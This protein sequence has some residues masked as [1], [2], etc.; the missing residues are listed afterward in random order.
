MPTVGHLCCDATRRGHFC[1][2]L[3]KRAKSSQNPTYPNFTDIT[4]T[5][6]LY[7]I[8]HT[9][10]YK[11]QMHTKWRNVLTYA[12]KVEQ[13]W[14]I[15]STPRF[16]HFATKNGLKTAESSIQTNMVSHSVALCIKCVFCTSYWGLC[17]PL[18][19]SKKDPWRE[20]LGQAQTPSLGE[21]IPFFHLLDRT[22]LNKLFTLHLYLCIHRCLLSPHAKILGNVMNKNPQN[23]SWTIPWSVP[24]FMHQI[25]PT[26]RLPPSITY[27]TTS[28]RSSSW[29]NTLLTGLNPTPCPQIPTPPTIAPSLL[30]PNPYIYVALLRLLSPSLHVPP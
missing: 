25:S 12:S 22:I 26:M 4:R 24:S 7:H 16:P 5:Y 14:K 28:W 20:K 11:N 9:K 29:P 1:P 21:W 17:E 8:I 6:E 27:T 15:D 13:K 3:Q 30:S 10:S 2:R 19:L 23:L 18:R